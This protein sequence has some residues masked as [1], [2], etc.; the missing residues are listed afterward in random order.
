[1][2]EHYGTIRRTLG[3]T[4]R[5][6]EILREPTEPAGTGRAIPGR[7]RGD[8][9]LI[10]VH[11][12]YPSRPEIP[13]LRGVSLTAAPGQRVALVGAS[14]AGK[15]T[16]VALLLRFY[17]PEKGEVLIDGLDARGYDLHQLRGQMALVPQDVILFGGTIAENIAYG[18][19]GA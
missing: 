17:E 19:P 15:S 18:K 6:R 12:R 10:D 8:V 5:V 3:A 7:L 2:A 1:F 9:A 13:V 16:L 4:Q 14:G 11:F